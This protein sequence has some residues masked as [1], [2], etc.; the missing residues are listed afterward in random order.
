MLRLRTA[1]VSALAAITMAVSTAVPSAAAPAAPPSTTTSGGTTV[2]GTTETSTSETMKARTS[3][4]TTSTPPPGPDQ[5]LPPDPTTEAAESGTTTT[6]AP[7]RPS[8]LLAGC[9]EQQF[10]DVAVTDQFCPQVT[11]LASTGVTTGYTDPGQAKPGFHPTASVSRQA[12]AAFLYRYGFNGQA[13]PACAGSF[14]LFGD[15]PAGGFCGSI[16]W[17]AGAGISGGY[18]DGGFHPTAAVSR[19]AMAAFLYRFAH[20]GQTAPA[21]TAQQFWDV[22]VGDPFCPQISWLASTG[23]TTGYTDSGHSQPGF[24]PASAVS[25]Q[26]MA[27]FLYRADDQDVIALNGAT[28]LPAVTGIDPESGPTAGGTTVT[29]TGTGL[30]GATQA[31][32]DLPGAASPAAGTNLVVVSATKVTVTAPAHAAGRLPVRVTTAAGTSVPATAT[33]TYTGASAAP[34]I[35]SISPATGPVTGGTTVT[36]TGTNLT[37]ATGVRFGSTPGTALSVT[38]PTSLTVKSPAGSTGAV[39]VSVTTRTA[40][41]LPPPDTASPTPQSVCRRIRQPSPGHWIRPPPPICSRR[42]PS[43]TPVTTRSRWASPPEPS[44]SSGPRC[45]AGTC[46]PG[47]VSRC[48]G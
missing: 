24:H 26:A 17:L 25:R 20:P 44:P 41:P 30:T 45:C 3:A 29:I 36:L 31:L 6:T 10:W 33:Y 8:A 40:P 2:T 21:C 39:D 37:G 27:A 7:S 38:S 19:Q 15:V 12:M 4:P 48:P 32:F 22:P 28:P 42:P 13:D 5:G 46:W 34:T 18:A 43:S 23:I 16:E 14:R 11:W 47:A 35:T 1:V 9:S